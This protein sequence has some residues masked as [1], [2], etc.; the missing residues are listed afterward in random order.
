MM[1]E[2]ER[3]HM[4]RMLLRARRRAKQAQKL[5][6]KWEK[7]QADAERRESELKQGK[8]WQDEIAVVSLNRT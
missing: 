2:R 8:L 5:V 7:R 4:E 1:T 6:E 3:A